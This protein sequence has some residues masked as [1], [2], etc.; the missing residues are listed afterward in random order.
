MIDELFLR[1]HR[2][3]ISQVDVDL[4]TESLLLFLGRNL[5]AT[6]DQLAEEGLLDDQAIPVGVVISS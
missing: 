5:Q 1:D 2:V 6:E 3:D 4:R